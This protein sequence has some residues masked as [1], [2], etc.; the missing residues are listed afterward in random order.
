[1]ITVVEAIIETTVETVLGTNTPGHGSAT[2]MSDSNLNDTGFELS[3]VMM[4][5]AGLVVL[6]AGLMVVSHRHMQDDR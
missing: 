5:G 2:P 4:A 3:T 6:A 1:M